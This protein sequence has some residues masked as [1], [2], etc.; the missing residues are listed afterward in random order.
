[1]ALPERA[2]PVRMRRVAVVALRGR[3]REVLV[4]LAQG[5]VVDLSGP[6]GSGEGP[7]LEALRRLER[8]GPG[9]ASAAPALAAE[10]PDVEELERS[11]AR[12]LLAGEV[13]LERRKASAVEH[14]EFAV[15][16]GWAPAPA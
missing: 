1:M 4:A 9:G 7:A 11:G 12:E 15:F 3:V 2:F 8:R 6:L 13:E 10:A 5:G 14:G 16:V